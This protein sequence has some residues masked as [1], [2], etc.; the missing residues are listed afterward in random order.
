MIRR[1]MH[2]V[3]ITDTI[4]WYKIRKQTIREWECINV[5]LLDSVLMCV[6]LGCIT[7]VRA[8]N[9]IAFVCAVGKSNKSQNQL[10]VA[11]N[12]RKKNTLPLIQSSQQSGK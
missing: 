4:L 9:V 8:H 5:L 2:A 6:A 7:Y 12:V 10:S 1:N 3:Y 11:C